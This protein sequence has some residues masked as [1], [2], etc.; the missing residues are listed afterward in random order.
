MK[1][2]LRHKI[3]AANLIVL[4]LTL[5]VVSFVVVQGLDALNL[6]MLVRNLIH[7]ADVSILSIRQN[8]L[9]G[10]KPSANE[11]EF[12]ARAKDFASKISREAGMRVLVFSTDKALVADSED[13]TLPVQRFNELDHVLN[14]NRT[15]VIRR[16]KGERHMYFAFPVMQGD[17]VIGEI[18]FVYPME[19]IDAGAR[20]VHT[21]LAFSFI[22]GIL[23]IL[24]SSV[25]MSHRITK[26]VEQLTR[27][28]RAIAGGSFK[29]KISIK[30]SDEVGELARA[31]NGMAD[32]IKNRIDQLNIE[33][34]KLSSILES[35]GEGVIALNGRNDVIA[36]NSTARSIVGSSF[37]SEIQMI[38]KRVKT[39]KSRVVLEL[40][41]NMK[42]LLICATPLNM[43]DSEEG[44]VIII[45]DITEL[46]ELQ[47]KQNLF[48]TNVSHELKTPLTT[49]TGYIELLKT[50]GHDKNVFETSVRYL[51]SASDRLLRL[52]NDLIDLSCL[53]K[54]EFEVEPKSTN[55]SSLLKDIVGQM[56][57]KAQKFKIKITTCIPDL[58]EI[59][60][61][62]VR[63]KQVVVN[64]LDNAI[65][66][67]Q[68]NNIII[69]LSENSHNTYIDI[70]DNG[71]GI[72][73]E[74][75]K[76]IFQPFQRVDKARSRNLGGNG[77]GLSISKEIIE[78]HGGKI[79]INSKEG[80]GT[81][82]SIILPS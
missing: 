28:A 10:D 72:P 74:M 1:L 35:M 43:N 8:L 48:L 80:Q 20:N 16:H 26:P 3:T 47:Q 29:H 21:V 33:K 13:K 59:L 32:E 66:H 30:S 5:A 7:Q 67:S 6:R 78:K 57:L 22:I 77:L 62:P 37:E 2:N 53:S 61:D 19:E 12:N 18:M 49:I 76:K 65:K 63:I 40:V 50:K 34:S 41:H 55:I 46:R 64:I 38:A 15:Y 36:V 56:S 44:I 9:Y 39:Q 54:F 58:P 69:E 52:V 60:V 75:L 70:T 27:S 17:N 11:E 51:Q 25:I 73:S 45:N 23:V 81:K 79:E 71:C 31:F 82:V 42:S 14:G 4:I 24:L 68:G